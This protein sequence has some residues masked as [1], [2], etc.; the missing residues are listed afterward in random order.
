[1]VIKKLT[2]EL[3]LC[4]C[5]QGYITYLSVVHLLIK[6]LSNYVLHY[7]YNNTSTQVGS[8]KIFIGVVCFILNEITH[9]NILT[10]K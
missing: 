8:D 1:M 7:L 5:T 10:D 6:T 2:F 3:Q 9:R 4:S